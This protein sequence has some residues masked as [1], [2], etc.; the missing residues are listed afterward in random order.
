MINP[1]SN[2]YTPW[3]QQP[4]QVPQQ[5]NNGIIWVQGEAAAKSYPVAAGNSLPLFD[6]ETNC[7][8]IKSC[9]ASGMP[10]PL[11][12]F[13]YTERVVVAKNETA[14]SDYVTREEFEKRIA[15]IIN[16][17]STIPAAE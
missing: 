3:Y 4:Q 6:S 9:D 1:F 15:E 11:R 12:V 16:A 2:S 17:K 10:Q 7:F 5:Q 13:D 8:Y 14:T